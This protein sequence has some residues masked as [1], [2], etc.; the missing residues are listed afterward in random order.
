MLPEPSF[1]SE[2]PPDEHAFCPPPCG[3]L[4]SPDNTGLLVCADCATIADDAAPIVAQV[5]S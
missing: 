3:G 2:W 4:M 1:P 5:M